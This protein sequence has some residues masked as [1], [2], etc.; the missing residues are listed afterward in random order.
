VETIRVSQPLKD[1]ALARCGDRNTIHRRI[2]RP[3][4]NVDDSTASVP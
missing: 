3:A 2:S 4:T 1:A